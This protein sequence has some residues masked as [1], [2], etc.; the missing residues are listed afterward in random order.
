MSAKEALIFDVN[1]G[2]S[3]SEAAEE[4]GVT[5][6]CAY[7]WVARYREYG[8]PGL[9]ERSRRPDRSPFQTDQEKVDELLALKGKHPAFGPAKLVLMAMNIFNQSK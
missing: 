6:S 7:K 4:H 9:E 8:W 3:V 2:M 5:R 1:D